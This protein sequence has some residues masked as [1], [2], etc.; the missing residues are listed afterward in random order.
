MFYG[1]NQ[2]N[3]PTSQ[4]FALNNFYGGPSS[5]IG[6]AVNIEFASITNVQAQGQDDQGPSIANQSRGAGGTSITNII[7]Q[8]SGQIIP[9]DLN[10]PTVLDPIQYVTGV[11]VFLSKSRKGITLPQNFAAPLN[12]DDF[13]TSDI[14]TDLSVGGSHTI[15]IPPI[16]N[17]ASLESVTITPGDPVSINTSYAISGSLN[18]T[19]T[20]PTGLEQTT[21]GI[22]NN[23]FSFI[24]TDAKIFL[25]PGANVYG[26]ATGT[27]NLSIAKAT[28]L[29]ANAGSDLVS[30]QESGNT[31]IT[32]LANASISGT[33]NVT[34]DIELGNHNEV[35]DLGY[36]SVS[37]DLGTTTVGI[38]MVTG[39]NADT[40][41]VTKS[42]VPVNLSLGTVTLNLP[43]G[44]HEVE[45]SLGTRTV[46]FPVAS[47]EFTINSNF[48]NFSVP[49]SFA[50]NL[51]QIQIAEGEEV[52]NLT[53]SVPG[54]GFSV[55]KDNS[56]AD[57]L[58][59]PT[60][61]AA[62]LDLSKIKVV[63]EQQTRALN[64]STMALQPSGS[65][66]LPA[67]YTAES[68]VVTLSGGNGTNITIDGSSFSIE[69]GGSQAVFSGIKP[70]DELSQPEMAEEFFVLEDAA[71]T[72]SVS[73]E[74][75]LTT[76]F[77]DNR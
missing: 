73:T 74:F 70:D 48:T 62:S 26:T 12:A 34:V 76:P 53:V 21:P 64:I 7:N 36:R 46:S 56:S 59:L 23:P 4:E 54:S 43:L 11:S 66:S 39:F 44:T 18:A 65:V 71:V 33:A 57:G 22:T 67:S 3:F 32:A 69:N 50:L 35:I 1:G 25:R 9:P 51:S 37:V 10:P 49:T 14:P 55:G 15:T 29:Q 60:N 68:G 63:T 58:A 16:P 28:G 47:D 52:V 2:F 5:Q 17:E 41:Q 72:T 20:V 40:C 75:A 38:E 31:S 77:G 24:Q 61:V 45:F 19:D 6:G 8:G 27:G 13:E 42:N 30:V